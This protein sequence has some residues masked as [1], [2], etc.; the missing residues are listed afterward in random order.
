[1]RFLQISGHI[2]RDVIPGDGL[3]DN[4]ADQDDSSNVDQSFFGESE[5]AGENGDADGTEAYDAD[6]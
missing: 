6:C 3:I 4:F 2:G 5:K 1:M